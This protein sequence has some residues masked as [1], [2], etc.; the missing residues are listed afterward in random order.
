MC[1]L[2]AYIVEGEQQKLLLEDVTVVKVHG[3]HVHLST[4]F[5]ESKEVEGRIRLLQSNKLFIDPGHVH[6]SEPAR[7]DAQKLAVLL[8]HWVEHNVEH[9][10]ELERWAQKAAALGKSEAHEE[11]MGAATRVEEAN[12][13]L[14]RAAASLGA[15]SAA[16]WPP[17][18]GQ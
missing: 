7:D 3:E 8:D 12:Q 14:R 16:V 18:Q 10:R 13:H 5:G 1:Q 4:L 15:P 9:N 17:L 2:T 11:M 6:P